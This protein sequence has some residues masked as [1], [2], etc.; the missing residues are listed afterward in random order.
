MGEG[1]AVTNTIGNAV[2]AIVVGK[3]SGRVDEER[4]RT[5]VG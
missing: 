5:D 3:W 1:M 4:L 2:A